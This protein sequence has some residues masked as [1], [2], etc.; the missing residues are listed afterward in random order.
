MNDIV[1]ELLFSST[2]WWDSKVEL[3]LYNYATK[4]DQKGA[5]D[6]D[7]STLTSKTDLGSLKT[8]VDSLDVDK[9]KTGSADLNKLSN[10]VDNGVAKKLC[11]INCVP[12]S[13]PLILRYPLLVD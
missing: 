10:V 3:N 9:I 8:K 12:N 11:V 2:F 4:G 5:T 6:I 1:Q 13:M 7:T